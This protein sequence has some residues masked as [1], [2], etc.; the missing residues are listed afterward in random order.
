MSKE[1]EIWQI[2]T[3]SGDEIVCEVIESLEHEIVVMNA[4]R[5][6]VY[7]DESGDQNIH[8]FKPWMTYTTDLEERIHISMANVVAYFS[9]AT[10]MQ[11]QYLDAL[12]TIASYTAELERSYMDFHEEKR[13][14]SNVGDSASSNV[15]T[16]FGGPDDTLH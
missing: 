16:L 4:L 9:P 10:V 13:A 2:K 14:E 11:L 6:C 3:S 8:V 15:V 12:D 7:I 1:N 5:L